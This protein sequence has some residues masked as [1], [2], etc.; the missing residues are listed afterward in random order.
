MSDCCA[1]DAANQKQRSLLWIVLVLNALMFVVEFIAG[2]FAQSSGLIADSLDMLADALVYGL[3]LYAVGRAATF[4]ARAAMVNGTLQLTLGC[5]V[6]VDVIK[7]I[8]LG[9]SPQMEIM[10][11]IGFLA[12]VVNICCFLLL[13]QFRDGDVNMRAS[14]ICSRNDMLA[15]AGVILSAWLVGRTASAWPDLLIGSLIALTVIVSATGV[16]RA[17][18]KVY[19]DEQKAHSSCCSHPH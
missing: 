2:W 12:L 3:S 9:S 17:A 7:R 6:M 14:W 18:R 15:N 5:L 19:Q 11:A 4:K 8:V 1:P 13:Y 10:Y 16:I